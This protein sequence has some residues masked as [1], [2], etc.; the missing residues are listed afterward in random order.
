MA[1]LTVRVKATEEQSKKNAAD[2]RE[3][4]T[5]VTAVKTDTEEII[6]F[7]RGA[8]VAGKIIIGFG[9]VA[10]WVSAIGGMVAVIW[11]LVYAWKHGTAP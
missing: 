8:K 6:A 10:K 7:F 5:I 11:A 4:K 1:E 3:L 2:L 9:K